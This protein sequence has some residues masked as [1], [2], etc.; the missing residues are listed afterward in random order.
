MPVH[1]SA[2]GITI[3]LPGTTRW[4]HRPPGKTCGKHAVRHAVKLE[5]I[6]HTVNYAVVS[7]CF[8]GG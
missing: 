3:F 6:K 2:A 5:E 1:P 8:P 4:D 7:Y